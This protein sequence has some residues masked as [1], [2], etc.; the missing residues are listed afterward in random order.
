MARPSERQVAKAVDKQRI[1]APILK[2]ANGTPE[3]AAAARK[4]ADMLNRIGNDKRTSTERTLYGWVALA[5]K[6][7]SA[8]LRPGIADFQSRA[9]DLPIDFEHQNDRKSDLRTGPVPAAGWIKEL[10]ADAAGLWGRV[11]WTAQARELIA[12]KA[13]RYLR[14]SFLYTKTGNAITHAL[15]ARSGQFRQLH[16]QGNTGPG[17]S[18]QAVPSVG[19]PR[20]P[21]HPP[22]P[23]ATTTRLSP[24]VRSLG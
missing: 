22:L 15:R 7:G 24:Y 10:K 1:I 5:E 16:C 3:R 4:V 19:H 14:P 20:R 23:P 12:S 21:S 2:E 17:P 6:D 13:Y 8:A 11:E 18:S 9:I